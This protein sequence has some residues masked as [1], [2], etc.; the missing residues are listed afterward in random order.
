MISK[1]RH[2][3]VVVRDLVKSLNFYEALGFKLASRQI[4]QG[5]FIDQVVGL[6]KVKVETAKLEFFL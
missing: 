3:G 2:T 1:I 4:E 6:K 5:D